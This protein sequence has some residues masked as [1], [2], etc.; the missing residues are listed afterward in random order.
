M[1]PDR[2]VVLAVA[3]VLLLVIGLSGLSVGLGL[4]VL[5]ANVV[6]STW[7]GIAIGAGI[8][9]YGLAAVIGGI[10]IWLRRS[11]RGW[12]LAVATILL[13]MGV[14]GGLSIVVGG[15]DREFGFGILVCGATLGCLLAP[16][17]RAAVGF[18]SAF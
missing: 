2:S 3:V 10:G 1:R 18:G 11:R 4:M 6:G 8:A 12:W 5:M 16:G 17:T 14:L 15:L 9:L 13:G 7:S